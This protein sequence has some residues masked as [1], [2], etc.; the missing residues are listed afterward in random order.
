MTYELHK[1]Q[2]T[3]DPETVSSIELAI[4]EI[5]QDAFQLLLQQNLENKENI[6]LQENVK[7]LHMCLLDNPARKRKQGR[8][9]SFQT[10]HKYIS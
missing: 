9:T 6:M 1:N 7:V 3:I 8:E 2:L 10:F 4:L 5:I